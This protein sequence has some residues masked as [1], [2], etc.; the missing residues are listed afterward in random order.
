MIC[1]ISGCK[2]KDQ[3]IS[4][5]QEKTS[6]SVELKEESQNI[7][8]DSILTTKSLTYEKSY[9][10]K[11][12]FQGYQYAYGD[13]LI[14]ENGTFLFACNREKQITDFTPFSIVLSSSSDS[15]KSWSVP[16]II[17]LSINGNYINVLGPSFINI[18]KGHIILFFGVKYS[19]ER[20]DIYMKESFDFG[21]TWQKEKIVYG[22]NQGYQTLNNNRVLYNNGRIFVPIAIP[23][24]AKDLYSS[25]GNNMSSFYYYSDDLGVTWKKSVMFSLKDTALL[26]P[27]IVKISNN[28]M[29][30]N[31]RLN[32]GRVL[33]ARTKNGGQSWKYEYSNI[34]SP[35]SPQKILN[36]EGSNSLL[37][38]WNNTNKNFGNHVGNRNP[39]TIALSR[40]K[41]RTWKVLGNLEET[42]GFDYSYPSM[43]QDSQNVY[44]TYYE[45]YSGKTGYAIK[46][47]RINKSNL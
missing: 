5:P 31:F 28:E 11:F 32:L 20:I 42:E 17:P 38:V 2:K 46:L 25:I 45:L 37:M 4:N 1:L 3:V 33:F 47:V 44:I 30:M 39:F 24:N 26:E 10:F 15:G 9:I 41:G 16:Q 18:G 14:L 21:N 36:I 35:S 7:K 19:M 43:T 22:I 29:L 8:I 40:D 23:N 27:D 6:D 13:L 12:G 34:K